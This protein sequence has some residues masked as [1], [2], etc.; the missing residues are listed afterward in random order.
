LAV[1]DVF[2]TALTGRCDARPELAAQPIPL[3]IHIPALPCRGGLELLRRRAGEG[4]LATH[5][6]KELITQHYWVGS[7]DVDKLTELQEMTER[8]PGRI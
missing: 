6:E 2:G 1:K 4:W 8:L 3:E 7:D 5:P